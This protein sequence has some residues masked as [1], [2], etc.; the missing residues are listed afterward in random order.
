MWVCDSR[1]ADNFYNKTIIDHLNQHRPHQLQGIPSR[2]PCLSQIFR[3]RI[4][5]RRQFLSPSHPPFPAFL[6]LP[7]F[8]CLSSL[9]YLACVIHESVDLPAKA[10]SSALPIFLC[11]AYLSY[12]AYLACLIFVSVDLPVFYI[13]ILYSC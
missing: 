8:P 3:A 11:L 7:A 1:T 13:V 4:L 2:Q 5:S 9:A 10:A 6:A 12:L